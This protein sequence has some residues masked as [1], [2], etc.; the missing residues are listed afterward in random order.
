MALHHINLTRQAAKS[1]SASI[2][3][4]LA[5]KKLHLKMLDGNPYFMY[6]SRFLQK[7]SKL[8][9]PGMVKY[10]TTVADTSDG[11]SSTDDKYYAVGGSGDGYDLPDYDDDAYVS[12][13]AQK[14]NQ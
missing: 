1:I 2:K 12:V 3:Y 13:D 11:G 7:M 10:N 14:S 9:V 5:K 6:R 8:R 4:F